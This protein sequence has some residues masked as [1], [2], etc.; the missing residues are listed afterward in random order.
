MCLNQAA[1]GVHNWGGKYYRNSERGTGWGTISPLRVS[2]SKIL[3]T[4]APRSKIA[5]QFIDT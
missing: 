3:Q 5:M 1:V 2:F 4:S